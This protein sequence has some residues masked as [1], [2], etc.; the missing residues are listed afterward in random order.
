MM[1][2]VAP[3]VQI[4]ILGDSVVSVGWESWVPSGIHM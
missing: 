3:L 2:G 1:V 4:E